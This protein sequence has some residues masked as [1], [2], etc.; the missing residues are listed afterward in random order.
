MTFADPS[1]IR[2][3]SGEIYAIVEAAP[4][5]TEVSNSLCVGRRRPQDTDEEVFLFLVMSLGHSLTPQLRDKLKLAIRQGLSSRHV[6]KFVIQ[7]PDIPVTINGKKVEIAVKQMM[8][9]KDVKASATVQ[10]PEAVEY[11]RRFRELES[12][13]RQVRL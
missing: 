10:N 5:N 7:V 13:P 11:F 9:G 2:F 6:P 1:G 4:F 12:E 8:S 3:G